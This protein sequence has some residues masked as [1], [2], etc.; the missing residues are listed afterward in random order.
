[1]LVYTIP[2]RFSRVK[3]A[4]DAGLRAF[5]RRR[6]VAEDLARGRDPVSLHVRDDLVVDRLPV[7]AQQA[8]LIE[9]W[10]SLQVFELESV[11]GAELLGLE[12]RQRVLRAQ[13]PPALV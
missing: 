9:Q 6:T 4:T 13:E 8:F 10:A 1:M 3:R 2:R 12:K 11:L 7:G 5:F